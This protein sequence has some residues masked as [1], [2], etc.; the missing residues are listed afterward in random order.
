M[1]RQKNTIAALCTAAALMTCLSGTNLFETG[2]TIYA[3]KPTSADGGPI[4]ID[5]PWS[6]E[7]GVL[8]LKTNAG[9]NFKDMYDENGE[10]N[11]DCAPWAKYKEYVTEV[12]IESVFDYVPGHAF[13]EFENLK[14]VTLHDG[15]RYFHD[16]AFENCTSLEE[17][18]LPTRLQRLGNECFRGCNSL[19]KLELP[20]SFNS[21]N[22]SQISDS[23]VTE[24]IFHNPE[25]EI[26]NDSTEYSSDLVIKSSSDSFVQEQADE[27]GLKFQ[28]AEIN[29]AIS[30]KLGEKIQWELKDGVLTV[31]GEGELFFGEPKD[32]TIS[33]D[34]TP[35]PGIVEPA[36]APWNDYLNRITEVVIDKGI[37]N[38]PDWTFFGAANLSKI[39]LPDSLEKI[40]ELAFA[41]CTKLKEIII[42]ESVNEIGQDAFQTNTITMLKVYSESFAAG[43]A[44]EN[45]LN[46][47]II[48]NDR[49]SEG[50][51]S[52][53]TEENIPTE[54]DLIIG[55]VNGDNERDMTDVSLL[56][57]YI[58]KETDFTPNQ[59]RAADIDQNSEVSIADL[60]YYLQYI[61]KKSN[62]FEQSQIVQQSKPVLAIVHQNFAHTPYQSVQ[63]I[64]DKGGLY[65][66]P[67]HSDEQK[68]IEI[69]TDGIT[70]D[71]KVVSEFQNIIS[72]TQSKSTVSSDILS[73]IKDTS[74]TIFASSGQLSLT[75]DMSFIRDY[76][77]ES[78][79]L[80]KDDSLIRISDFG[81]VC[82]LLDDESAHELVQ[83]LVD[84][85]Y[86]AKKQD[87]EYYLSHRN[88]EYF[89]EKYNS[90]VIY[91]TSKK[92]EYEDIPYKIFYN[93]TEDGKAEESVQVIKSSEEYEKIKSVS[94]YT[95][96]LSKAAKLSDDYFESGNR[97]LYIQI[98]VGKQNMEF[99][100]KSMEL[101]DENPD[102][103]TINYGIEL[104]GSLDK[105]IMY[106]NVFVCL[107]SEI[108]KNTESA[109][110]IEVILNKE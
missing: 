12:V 26:I 34:G 73:K 28:E 89:S 59:M 100:Y 102:R 16:Y 50:S 95:E 29:S 56:S 55:D 57:L 90:Y 53:V 13:G 98:P 15:I 38:L 74:E 110:D 83:I 67:G 5:S 106:Y 24:I 52:D 47:T 3:E 86:Y 25:C 51:G 64:D 96:A 37:T 39:T 60:S 104:N 76:G 63:I 7:K 14:K 108:V 40:G 6:L 79:Y 65:E 45:K 69:E 109:G 36:R 9:L 103:I 91:S 107:P 22:L 99:I 66:I 72:D 62:I 20:A 8:T 35:L 48:E 42:P 101:S 19:K 31:T 75:D 93:Y 80:V 105:E 32:N 82:R 84:A 23:G 97:L 71:K 61:S 81:D 58:L 41:D 33:S 17:I 46:Y 54:T 1:K 85:G 11:H 21:F 2:E 43:Y 30:D 94:N 88:E 70:E 44:K 87:F 49:N 10:I 4:I 78:L 27:I 77:I 18:A 92:F 68:F